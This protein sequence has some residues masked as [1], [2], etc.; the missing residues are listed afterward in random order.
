[1]PWEKFKVKSSGTSKLLN[2]TTDEIRG[3]QI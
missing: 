3:L 1:M 2:T